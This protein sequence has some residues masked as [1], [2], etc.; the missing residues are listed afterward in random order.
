M[1]LTVAAR[2]TSERSDREGERKR[3]EEKREA[4]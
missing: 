3:L 2:E 1:K 4:R